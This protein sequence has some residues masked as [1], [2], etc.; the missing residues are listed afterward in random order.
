[1]H[2]PAQ[3][4]SVPGHTITPQTPASPSVQHAPIMQTMPA[5]QRTPH[6]PQLFGSL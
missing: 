6:A 5:P 1:M 4:I 2:V 3:F